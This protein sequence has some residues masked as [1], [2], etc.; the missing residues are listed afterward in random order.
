MNY[1]YKPIVH[2]IVTYHV[3]TEVRL[4]GYKVVHKGTNRRVKSG[5]NINKDGI[6]SPEYLSAAWTPD[7]SYPEGMLIV[8]PFVGGEPKQVHPDD[9]GIEIK[10]E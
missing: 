5:T 3:W 7:A 2:K 8:V 9:Y 4:N 6:G 1:E 10:P